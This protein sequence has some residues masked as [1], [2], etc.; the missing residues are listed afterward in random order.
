MGRRAPSIRPRSGHSAASPR[1][2]LPKS[3][4]RSVPSGT[5][6]APGPRPPRPLPI[7]FCEFQ[8]D[9]VGQADTGVLTDTLSPMWNQSITPTNTNITPNFLISQ[10]GNW[11]IFVGDD[12]GGLQRFENVCTVFPMLTAANF[13]TGIVKFANV[14]SCTSLTIQ[15]VCAQN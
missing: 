3:R 15:L 8:L 11:S 13:T 10:A 4:D 2:S 9:K 6:R 14:Q 1:Q 12:D 7:R 5:F